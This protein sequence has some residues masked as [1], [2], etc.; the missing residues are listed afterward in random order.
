MTRPTTTKTGTP[1]GTTDEM[2]E[3][4]KFLMA[5]GGAVLISW[6]II[7]IGIAYDTWK[8]G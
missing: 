8:R 2:R 1:S 5:V 3:F 6:G 7:R 4:I